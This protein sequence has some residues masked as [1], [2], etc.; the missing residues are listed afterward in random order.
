LESSRAIKAGER[1]NSENLVKIKSFPWASGAARTSGGLQTEAD[2]EARN[3]AI[4]SADLHLQLRKGEPKVE[5]RLAGIQEGMHT[6][7]AATRYVIARRHIAEGHHAPHCS[8]FMRLISVKDTKTHHSQNHFEVQ[9]RVTGWETQ[10]VRAVG[11]WGKSV[12]GK[13][14]FGKG[15]PPLT[16]KSLSANTV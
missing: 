12:L 14:A 1:E 9:N 5:L 3:L 15:N 6:P 10:V 4:A 7:G 11:A 13:L 16:A 2:T 8:R